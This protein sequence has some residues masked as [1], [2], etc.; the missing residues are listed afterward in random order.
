MV[1]LG[2][3][4]HAGCGYMPG[5][6]P[7][8]W[9]LRPGVVTW[10]KLKLLQFKFTSVSLLESEDFFYAKTQI[11]CFPTLL[12]ISRHLCLSKAQIKS[13]LDFA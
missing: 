9:G 5:T 4:T 2:L 6:S 8:T 3:G 12:L 10:V 7:V 11:R 13:R 1:R